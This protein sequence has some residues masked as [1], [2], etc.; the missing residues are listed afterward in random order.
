M[1]VKC[2]LLFYL[3][4]QLT[5]ITVN[6][7]SQSKYLAIIVMLD[8][9]LLCN[10]TKNIVTTRQTAHVINNVMEKRDTDIC[11]CSFQTK[12]FC[13]PCWAIQRLG[14]PVYKRAWNMAA[15]DQLLAPF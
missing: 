11:K 1:A 2:Y 12:H 6:L 5:V 10:V 7:N 3:F 9:V 13:F 4:I 15:R 14:I 8:Q